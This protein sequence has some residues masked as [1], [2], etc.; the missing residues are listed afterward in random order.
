MFRG[1]TVFRT[2]VIGQ[3]V[4][5][6]IIV[7]SM[8][9]P[10]WSPSEG[11]QHG[12]CMETTGN[13]WSLLW[14][15]VLNLNVRIGSYSRHIGYSELEHMKRIDIFVY[16]TCYLETMP[17]SRIVKKPVFYFQNKVVF[18]PEDRPA[19]IC[20][21]YLMKIKLKILLTSRETKINSPTVI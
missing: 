3:W 19:D 9:T 18:R 10:C 14:L 7:F 12:S 13:I 11:L 5:L 6:K 17:M 20:D 21:F 4:S 16:P 15:S 1:C 8:E 2:L